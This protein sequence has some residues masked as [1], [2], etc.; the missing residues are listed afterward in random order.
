MSKTIGQ[1]ERC[2]E[3]EVEL[4]VATYEQYWFGE[5]LTYC[6]NCADDLSQ[7]AQERAFEA[8]WRG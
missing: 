6:Q 5:E 2:E 4:V 1:C 8:Y 3:H 7:E